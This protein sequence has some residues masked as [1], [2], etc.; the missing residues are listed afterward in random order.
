MMSLD[1]YQLAGE[2]LDKWLGSRT[3]VTLGDVALNLDRETITADEQRRADPKLTLEI[4]RYQL[5]QGT[6]LVSGLLRR[7]GFRKVG[8][9]G[10]SYGREPLYRKETTM[11]IGPMTAKSL[12]DE[13]RP[14]DAILVKRGAGGKRSRVG[15]VTGRRRD[16]RVLCLKEAMDQGGHWGGPMELFRDALLG[17]ASD[18]ELAAAVHRTSPLPL[19]W[20]V[21]SPA[22]D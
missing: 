3:E 11:V 18:E 21:R 7:R 12:Y 13:L 5:G 14:G 8:M 15:L 17:R 19:A 16:G 1:A 4:R 20:R 22:N 6:R 2:L 9:V 10:H